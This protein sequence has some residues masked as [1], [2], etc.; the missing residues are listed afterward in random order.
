MQQSNSDKEINQ[1]AEVGEPID[2]CNNYLICDNC[3]YY[4][5]RPMHG[6]YVCDACHMPTKC[7]EGMPLDIA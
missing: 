3:Q 2:A 4:P 6:H 1:P 5:L 7:C